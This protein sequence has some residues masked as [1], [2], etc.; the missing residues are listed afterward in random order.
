MTRICYSLANFYKLKE[1]PLSASRNILLSIHQN[2]ALGHS[3]FLKR[4]GVNKKKA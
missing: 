4:V 1:H 3:F 2:L